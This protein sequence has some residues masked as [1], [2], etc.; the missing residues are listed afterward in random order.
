MIRT[1]GRRLVIATSVFALIAIVLGLGL[2]LTG[3]SGKTTSKPHDGLDI[4]ADGATDTGLSFQAILAS[5]KDSEACRQAIGALNRTLGAEGGTRIPPLDADLRD[6]VKQIAGVDAGDFEEIE[7]TIYSPLDVHHLD[8]CL[9]F[10]DAAHALG[11]LDADIKLT[12]PEKARVAFDWVMRQVRLHHFAW[13]NEN[14]RP[15]FSPPNF[16]LRRGYGNSQDRA[17]CFLALLD[18]IGCDGCLLQFARF[19]KELEDGTPLHIC[20]VLA[21]EGDRSDIYL[22]DTFLGVPLPGTD[23][24]GISTLSAMQKQPHLYAGFD[25]DKDESFNVSP[26]AALLASSISTLAP[27][28]AELQKQLVGAGVK[29][30]L[31]D[32]DLPA[33]KQRW[34]AA[35][36]QAD[37]PKTVTP[38]VPHP[39]ARI[40]RDFLPS[41]EGGLDASKPPKVTRFRSTMVD[42][43]ELP[44]DVYEIGRQPWLGTEP[45]DFLGKLFFAF[46][47]EPKQE[48]DLLLRG[49]GDFKDAVAKLAHDCDEFPNLAKRLQIPLN[50]ESFDNLVDRLQKKKNDPDTPDEQRNVLWKDLI[51][52]ELPKE[53]QAWSKTAKDIF[54]EY[55]KA[56]SSHSDQLP[57]L[58]AQLSLNLQLGRELWH[59]YFRARTAEARLV[60]AVYQLAL[61]RH[62][63]AEL[64]DRLVDKARRTNPGSV[65]DL[66][67]AAGEA[68]HVAAQ[69]WKDF[70]E[71]PGSADPQAI[72]QAR[73]YRARAEARQGNVNA[74]VALLTTNPP[75]LHLSDAEKSA[76]AFL[77]KQ[78]S[79]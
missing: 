42:W 79:K 17:L 56:E 54:E 31:A 2:A 28:N 75:E 44:A 6:Q 53:V 40:L 34:E 60:L 27:R 65:A 77:A 23:G 39:L 59:P 58:R 48:H 5:N 67:V 51:N 25:A 41:S 33:R 68:W 61:C 8:S 55:R 63:M 11:L 49:Q 64:A 57:E 52:A 18:Q 38:R 10:N 1:H 22:F 30:R 78:L 21:K 13:D 15:E 69:A 16:V 35:L 29:I 14:I 20:G 73:F 36:K 43:Q 3:C 37:L 70:M 26:A 47:D 76:R 7:R 4:G 45:T 50:D 46:Y 9:L 32:V 71:Q 62:E 74:A 12:T 66:E 24:K 19:G 72:A